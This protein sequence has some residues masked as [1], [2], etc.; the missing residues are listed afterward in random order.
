MHL[1][2]IVSEQSPGMFLNNDSKLFTSEA[3]LH[4]LQTCINEC[5]RT[6]AWP[7]ALCLRIPHRKGYGA[8]CVGRLAGGGGCNPRGNEDG[9]KQIALGLFIYPKPRFKHRV[10]CVSNWHANRPKETRPYL[11]Q[12]QKRELST[13]ADDNPCH[14]CTLVLPHLYDG[15]YWSIK[16]V[17]RFSDRVTSASADHRSIEAPGIPYR[18]W[19]HVLKHR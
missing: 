12:V 8:P 18:N 7:K 2:S 5:P 14:Y 10:L 19:L 13:D 3:H 15:I 17:T 11:G 6:E 16:H 9:K 1:D 4:S